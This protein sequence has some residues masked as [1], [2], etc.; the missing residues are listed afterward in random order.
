MDLYIYRIQ[1]KT[2]SDIEYEPG[3]LSPVPGF[4]GRVKAVGLGRGV[5]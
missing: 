4:R 2:S 5:G 1:P 3:P